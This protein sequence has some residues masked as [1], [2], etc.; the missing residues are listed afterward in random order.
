MEAI[1]ARGLFVLFLLLPAAR[2]GGVAEGRIFATGRRCRYRQR[3]W[4]EGWSVS[5]ITRIPKHSPPRPVFLVIIGIRGES[6]KAERSEVSLRDAS[7]CE[8][9]AMRRCVS[10][11]SAGSSP[12]SSAWAGSSASAVSASERCEKDG[13]Q[14]GCASYQPRQHGYSIR[15]IN[16]TTGHFRMR[17]TRTPNQNSPNTQAGRSRKQCRRGTPPLS[18]PSL[19]ILL[20]GLPLIRYDRFHCERGKE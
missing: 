13:W 7:V 12:C 5:V 10:S 8:P 19:H 4:R 3:R 17:R 11:C 6:R 2:S 20:R 18:P 15:G 9:G 1:P 16:K 14:D